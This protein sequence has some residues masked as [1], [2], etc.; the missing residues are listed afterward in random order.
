M[1]IITIFLIGLSSFM[2]ATAQNSV[3]EQVLSRDYTAECN[4]LLSDGK[5]YDYR[6]GKIAEIADG[7]KLLFQQRELNGEEKRATYFFQLAGI[8]PKQNASALTKFLTD[9]VV[10]QNVTIAGN[11]KNDS[12]TSLYGNVWVAGVGDVNWHLLK[13]GIADFLEPEYKSISAYALC[14]YRQSAEKAKSE[15]LGIWANR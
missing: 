1:K 15:R 8:D 9:K 12:D 6:E 7:N 13:N 3:A 5:V 4:K 14:V 11:V 10:G 2:M